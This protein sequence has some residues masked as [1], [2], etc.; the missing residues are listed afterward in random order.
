MK[1]NDVLLIVL[2][3]VNSENSHVRTSLPP[4][5]QVMLGLTVRRERRRKERERERGEEFRC[6]GDD[7]YSSLLKTL[8]QVSAPNV[9][10]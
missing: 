2:V 1:T 3:G 10:K 7:R 6:F 8:S 4:P 5:L 9:R